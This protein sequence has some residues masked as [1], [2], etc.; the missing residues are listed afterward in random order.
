MAGPTP[1]MS[2]HARVSFMCQTIEKW[3]PRCM[4]VDYLDKVSVSVLL[5]SAYS[6]YCKFVLVSQ[7]LI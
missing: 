6:T 1:S 2:K 4:E 7:K 5:D 3:V